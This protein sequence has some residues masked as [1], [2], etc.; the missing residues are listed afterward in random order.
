MLE[1]FYP[2]EY[3]DSVYLINYEEF[4]RDGYRGIIYDIDNTL[5]PHGAPADA[6][7]KSLFSYLGSLGFS[8]CLLSNNHRERVEM[9]MEGIQGME[10]IQVI[11]GEESQVYFIEDAHKPS[12]KGYEEAMKVMGTTRSTTLSIGDQIFTDIWGSKRAGLYSILVKPINP[13]EEIQIVLKRYL[14]RIV[15]FFYRKKKL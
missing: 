10:E 1:S 4:Y 15:L 9:F 2:D 12:R 11:P 8:C 7:A 3:L 14:E 13:K 5:V 6:R